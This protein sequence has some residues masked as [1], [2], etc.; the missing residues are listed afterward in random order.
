MST[1]PNLM[2]GL[3]RA[4]FA[5]GKP[6]DARAT[7]D[8]LIQHNP[9]FRSADGHLLYAR[10]LEAEGQSQRA[11]EEYKALGGYYPGA[12]ASRALRAAAARPGA[13]R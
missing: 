3:A 8:A 2:L 11:L 1:T 7:L 10:A 5:A 6:A 4:Q 13:A 12:E 9:E